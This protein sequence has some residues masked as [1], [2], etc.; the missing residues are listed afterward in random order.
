MVVPKWSPAV[1]PTSW[2]LPANLLN[3]AIGLVMKL[4][5]LINNLCQILLKTALI[6]KVGKYDP[7]CWLL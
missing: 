4:G 2:L 3:I 5:I 1:P 6:S 7:S